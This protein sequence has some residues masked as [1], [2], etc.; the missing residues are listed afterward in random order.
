[1]TFLHVLS[2]GLAGNPSHKQPSVDPHS[3]TSGS[4]TISEAEHRGHLHRLNIFQPH[5]HNQA[6]NPQESVLPY[7]VALDCGC[8]DEDLDIS[9]DRNSFQ[10]SRLQRETTGSENEA[11]NLQTM[12]IP[13]RVDG[14]LSPVFS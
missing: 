1:M 5:R 8:Q 14:A 2:C 10:S 9:R 12:N 13:I 3:N 7:I 6:D 4:R 11:D